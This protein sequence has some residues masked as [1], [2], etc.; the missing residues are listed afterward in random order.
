[1]WHHIRPFLWYVSVCHFCQLPSLF[2][3]LSSAIL[4]QGKSSQWCTGGHPLLTTSLDSAH[5]HSHKHN[6]PWAAAF[7]SSGRY[8]WLLICLCMQCALKHCTFCYVGRPPTPTLKAGLWVFLLLLGDPG[9][10]LLYIDWIKH[11]W[12]FIYWS[13]YFH[14]CLKCFIIQK[15]FPNATIDQILFTIIRGNIICCCFLNIWVKN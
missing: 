12:A 15:L 6:S 9:S 1:M 3:P 10:T 7:F 5:S 4:S 14:V 11:M 8:G 13:L 2:D